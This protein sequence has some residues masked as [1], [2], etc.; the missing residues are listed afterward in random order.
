MESLA[1]ELLDYIVS[2]VIDPFPSRYGIHYRN[3]LSLSMV[4]RQL[5]RITE[6][7]IYR[8]LVMSGN[9]K[10]K[11]LRTIDDRPDLRQYATA[12]CMMHHPDPARHIMDFVT[13]LP[14][15]RS[16][17]IDIT[18]CKLIDLVSVLKLPSITTLYLSGVVARQIDDG[19]VD[20]WKFAN[21][22]ITTLNISFMYAEDVWEDCDEIWGFAAV[23][24]N[25]RCLQIHG[26][27][28]ADR[29]CTLNGPVYR[30]LVHAFRNA[31]R[32]TLRDFCFKYNDVL[33]GR[34]YGGNESISDAFDA[35]AI[36][37]KSQLEHLKLET[38]C[39]RRARPTL[40]SLE[41]GPSSLPSTLRTLYIRHEVDRTMLNP[42]EKNLMHSEEAQCL[43]QL[44][45]L[46]ARRSRFPLLQKMTLVIFLP[47]WFEEVASRVVKVQARR[48]KV[49]LDL[50]FA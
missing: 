24:R 49:H 35:R 36:L 12:I 28:S 38:D 43:S 46:A 7:Y 30:C 13:R 3:L 18:S 34:G 40:R 21:D 2:Q 41:V 48:A 47:S 4:S 45:K 9:L 33:H 15:L 17:D 26:A 14:N 27:H 19:R 44:V 23:F 42:P 32:T 5:R 20:E 37:Q 29:I 11:L 22:Y 50:I 10:Y 8:F 39:L 25:L 31:F 6:P 1:E 16:L